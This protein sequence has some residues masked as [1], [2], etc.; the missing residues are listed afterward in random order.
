LTSKYDDLILEH[1]REWISTNALVGLIHGNKTL[2][3][4]AIKSNPF[5][6]SRKIGNRIEYK[7]I[8]MA[9]TETQFNLMFENAFEWN[10]NIELDVIDKTVSITKGEGITL[11]KK[12]KDLL[13]HIQKEVDSAYIVIVR[14]KYQVELGILP[15]NIAQ[16]RITRLENHIKKI[17]TSLQTNY[18]NKAIKEYF[19]NHV[20]KFEFKI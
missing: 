15:N 1:T 11:T 5:L 19:Q 4:K 16:P 14:I 17:M 8:D 2:I 18:P 7:R 13:D 20:K 3:L 6:E 10:Q 9:E 12:G